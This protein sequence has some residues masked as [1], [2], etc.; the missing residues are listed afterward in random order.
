MHRTILAGDT[1][2]RKEMMLVSDEITESIREVNSDGQEIWT[3]RK[4]KMRV[5]VTYKNDIS[6]EAISEC[7]KAYNELFYKFNPR[8]R[9]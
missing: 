3:F 7:N 6:Q 8:N 5:K 2:K 1:I 4:G 9:E